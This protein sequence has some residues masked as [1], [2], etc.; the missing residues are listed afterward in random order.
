MNGKQRH[1][2]SYEEMRTMYDTRRTDFANETD[3]GPKKHNTKR[4]SKARGQPSNTESGSDDL[5]HDQAQQ[6]E[7][8][9]SRC[10][11]RCAR[12]HEAEG[13]RHSLRPKMGD[14]RQTRSSS[15]Q[16]KGPAAS[17]T[18]QQKWQNDVLT[19]HPSDLGHFEP[20]FSI[21]I[22]SPSYN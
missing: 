22:F 9:H 19:P 10:R 17:P 20:D 18:E 3:A 21:F 8:H 5:L 1:L 12:E 11:R 7:T 6:R 14:E 16:N 2:H 15:E 13:T 4:G